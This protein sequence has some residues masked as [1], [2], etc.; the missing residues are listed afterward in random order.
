[1]KL[2]LLINL[3]IFAYPPTTVA[4]ADVIRICQIATASWLASLKLSLRGPNAAVCMN[5]AGKWGGNHMRIVAGP[6][7]A[8]LALPTFQIE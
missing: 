1:M 6:S 5:A 4:V 2:V 7:V 3:A 8:P